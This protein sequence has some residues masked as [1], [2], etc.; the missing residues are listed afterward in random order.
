MDDDQIQELINYLKYG[1]RL[2][3][4]C[5]DNYREILHICDRY[6]PYETEKDA[7]PSGVLENGEYISLYSTCPEDIVFFPVRRVFDED[8]NQ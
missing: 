2:A 5:G 4:K 8:T 3:W 1:T 7:E 6:E